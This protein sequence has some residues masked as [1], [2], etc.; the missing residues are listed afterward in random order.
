MPYF[1]VMLSG[2]AISYG[3]DDGSDPAIGFF[4]TR[5]VKANDHRNAERL[6]KESVLLEW[7]SGGEYAERNHGSLPTLAAED[8]RPIGYLRGLFGRRDGGYAFYT[9]D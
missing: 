7:Q 2:R 5:T 4:T 1:R 3:F 9:G 6:A 8:V